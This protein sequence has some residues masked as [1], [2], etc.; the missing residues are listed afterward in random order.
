[1]LSR[2][3]TALISLLRRAEV[4]RAVLYGVLGVFR[5]MCTGPVTA[6]LIITY[7]SPVLQGYFYTFGSLLALQTFAD[8]GLGQVIVQFTSH[9]WAGLHLDEH[10]ALGGEPASLS[11]LAS[12]QQGAVRWY[13]VASGVA[14]ATLGVGGYVFFATAPQV[15]VRW[16]LPWECLCVV[17]AAR[18]LLV[19]LWSVLEGTGHVAEV[20]LY[21]LVEGVLTAGVTWLAVSSGAGLWTAAIASCVG[22]GYAVVVLRRHRRWL[23]SL[24]RHRGEP[25]I[26]WRSEVWPMQWRIALGWMSGYVV[27]SLFTPVLF[28]CHGAAVAGQMGMTWS[29]VTAVQTA[30]TIWVNT[31]APRFG[32]LIAR[33]AWGELDSLYRRLAIVVFG[34]TSMGAGV[35]WAGIYFLHC[36]HSRWAVRFLP[37]LPAGLFLLTTV[38]MAISVPQ[39]IYLRAHRREPFLA[40][41]VVSA[42]LIGS[43]TVVLGGAYGAT[44]MASGYLAVVALFSTP[45]TTAI[46]CRCRTLWHDQEGKPS[47]ALDAL[48]HKGLG[49][50]DSGMQVSQDA[51]TFSAVHLET[52]AS[53]PR[54][55]I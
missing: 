28:R 23:S 22:F 50:V 31:R 20:N 54:G 44:G 13:L 2:L 5:G 19:P 15:G 39:S 33:R 1:M 55:V 10:G 48:G 29:L 21:R 38:F 35:T 52:R 47:I 32:V 27:F 46:W 3:R 43:S 37:P 17:T 7:F 41:S 25:F 30:A 40:P 14:C 34:V 6:I 11:R 53:N 16:V 18:L 12:L 42:L 24:L 26:N 8:L 45:V 9:E 49:R 4:D 36:T 51:A